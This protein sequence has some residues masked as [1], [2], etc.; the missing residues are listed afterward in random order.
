MGRATNP[1]PMTVEGTNVV[2]SV[3]AEF[4]NELGFRGG[5]YPLV[6]VLVMED[7][8]RIFAAKERNLEEPGVLV[9][10]EASGGTRSILAV[11]VSVEK[12]PFPF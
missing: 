5:P 1:L 3:D 12:L 2:E 9:V 6:P 10:Q 4:N 7:G 8:T 11:K